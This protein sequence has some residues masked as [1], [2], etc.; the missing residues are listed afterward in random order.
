MN[1]DD[2]IS[3]HN[4]M[5]EAERAAIK[6]FIDEIEADSSNDDLKTIFDSRG[7]HYSFAN[8]RR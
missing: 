5:T 3:T 8:I 4:T 2:K 6:A 1:T 7:D